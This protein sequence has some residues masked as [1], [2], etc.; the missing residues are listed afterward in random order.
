MTEDDFDEHA[1][2]VWPIVVIPID[3]EADRSL[4]EALTVKG[5]DK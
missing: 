5:H 3:P 1:V 2:Q 4:D